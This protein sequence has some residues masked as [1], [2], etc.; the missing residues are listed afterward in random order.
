MGFL[1][2]MASQA[3][4]GGAT[5]QGGGDMMSAVLG[6]INSHGGVGGLVQAFQNKGLGGLADSWVGTG[7]NLP[8]TPDQVQAA[9]GSNA[10]SDIAAKL[11]LP[12]SVVTDQLTALLPG[13]I[14]HLT[15]NGQVPQ[16]MGSIGLEMLQG[17]LSKRAGQ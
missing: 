14:D 15:P 9:V 10:I 12:H 17:M 4:G 3:L 8:A 11:G 2:D 5:N 16:G 1:E 7:P 6:M 13:I